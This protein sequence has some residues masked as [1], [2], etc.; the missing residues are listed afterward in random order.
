MPGWL[1][2][3]GQQND[4][5]RDVKILVSRAWEMPWWKLAERFCRS[6]DTLRRWEKNAIDRLTLRYWREIDAM[7]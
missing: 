3:L 4:G 2:W 5:E 1:T 6:D 7:T